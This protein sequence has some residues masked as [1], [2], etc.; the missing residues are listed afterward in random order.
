M[1]ARGTIVG[2]TW[3]RSLNPDE[4][5]EDQAIVHT[6]SKG[7]V[8][9]FTLCR[10]RATELN[11]WVTALRLHQWS[12]N[13]LIFVPLLLSHQVQGW[14]LLEAM[15]SFFAF[16]L[17]ASAFY[18]LND[19]LDTEADRAH[20]RKANRPFA[21]GLLRTQQGFALFAACFGSAIALAWTLPL[22]ARMVLLLYA[23]M[24]LGYSVLLKQIAFLDVLVLA[25]L[26]DCR[27]LFG[28]AAEGIDVSL[29]TLTFSLL[30][31]LGL[32]FIKRWTELLS[33][34]ERK[35]ERL[36]GRGY[37]SSHILVVRSLAQWLLYLSLVVFGLYINSM[38]AAKLYR[39]PQVLWLACLLLFTWIRRVTRIT[40]GGL[41]ADD[42]LL[43][44]FKD[45][46]T[47][48]IAVL[49]TVSGA[50]AIGF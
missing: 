20:P 12:K 16:S 17:C 1:Q 7:S 47:Q 31:F 21:A 18:V 22:S 33:I 9:T 13:V 32:A 44:A 28:A 4:G 11:P 23:V 50:L 39:H 41:M 30:L 19:V 38:A 45:P 35:T 40:S 26:Y 8:S 14:R 10:G 2:R 43:F 3:F 15:R 48:V 25:L 6:S 29:W 36:A 27:L 46:G 34:A 5:D 24:N 49:V 37:L 42:P